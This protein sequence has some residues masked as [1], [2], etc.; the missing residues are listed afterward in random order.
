MFNEVI[1]NYSDRES[2]QEFVYK[3]YKSILRQS[4]LDVGADEGYIKKFLDRN[5]KYIGVGLGGNNPEIINC[6]LEIEKLPF[7]DNAFNCVLC[8]DVLEHLENIH[9]VF[10]ELCRVSNQYVLISLPNPYADF[11][12]YLKAGPYSSKKNM[13]YYS[14]LPEREV[15]R[16]KWFFSPT[17]AKMFI[18]YRSKKLGFEIIDFFTS[19]QEVTNDISFKSKIEPIY[20]ENLDLTELTS[21]TMWWVLE[22]SDSMQLKLNRVSQDDY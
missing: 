22:K 10:D 9:E 7:N 19:H 2:R 15:D 11:I 21:S 6:N 12:Q 5:T 17:E 4:V 3:K 1:E 18:E 14:L 13:K 20:H 8:L 16:H